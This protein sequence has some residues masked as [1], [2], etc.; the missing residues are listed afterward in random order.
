MV[1]VSQA[2]SGEIDLRN[3]IDT[4]MATALRHAGA[5][6]GL[7]I[8]PKDDELRIEAEATTIGD[9]VEVRLQR[10]SVDSTILP[11]FILRYVAADPG[12]PAAGRR[13]GAQ[14][15]LGR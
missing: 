1:K 12:E 9:H 3:L 15:L 2:V 13:R 4:L 10:A 5:D 6:R 11:E 14:S 8:L 7:L